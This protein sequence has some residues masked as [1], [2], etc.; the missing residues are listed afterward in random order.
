MLCFSI[1][2][3]FFYN[4]IFPADYRYII[5]EHL[6]EFLGVKSFRRRYPDLERR[7]LDMAEKEHLK[8]LAI[9]LESECELG[10]SSIIFP[11]ENEIFNLDSGFY[12]IFTNLI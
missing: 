6:S 10:E 11:S 5:Q 1:S 7:T 3:K 12:F 8:K 4:Y 2:S 9:V